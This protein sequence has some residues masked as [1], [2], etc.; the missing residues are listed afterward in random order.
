MSWSG[1]LR[2]L[3]TSLNYGLALVPQ[4]GAARPMATL[5]QMHRRGLPKRPPAPPGPTEGRPQLKGV[6]LR[7]F[8]RKPKKPNS[9]NRK[10]CRVRLS[11]GRE[12]VCFIPG[13]GHSLQEHH[14]VLVK[15][16]RTQDLPGVKLTIVRGKY[17]CGHVQK[18]K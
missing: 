1:L 18:K 10:C 8:I 13:E 16:G 14:V 5:N 7:T 6:V 15:G 4:L 11:T 3:N 9:A 17:D 2:G 12:A